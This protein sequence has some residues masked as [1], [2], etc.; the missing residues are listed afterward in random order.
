MERDMKKELG[1]SYSRY[2]CLALGLLFLGKQEEAEVTLEA[3][4]IIPGV[5]GKYAILTVETCA[6]CG[7]GNVLKVQKLLAECGEHITE[8]KDVWQFFIFIFSFFPSFFAILL[9]IN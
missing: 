8:E 4:K 5:M 2:L 9:L 6:Y 7:T 1:S 3:L